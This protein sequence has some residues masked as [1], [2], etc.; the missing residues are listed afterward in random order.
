MLL[1]I[2]ILFIN[3]NLF[4]DIKFCLKNRIWIFPVCQSKE[5]RN[6]PGS[7]FVVYS[8]LIDTHDFLRKDWA[9]DFQLWHL[10]YGVNHT[11]LGWGGF[12]VGGFSALQPWAVGFC[13]S[14]KQVICVASQLSFKCE[15]CEP[16]LSYRDTQPPKWLT[17]YSNHLVQC[18]VFGCFCNGCSVL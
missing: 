6:K 15:N 7:P 16:G 1:C 5:N 8:V 14:A 12:V 13:G 17:Q 2:K 9:G 3:T 11:S 18:L 10:C 4:D